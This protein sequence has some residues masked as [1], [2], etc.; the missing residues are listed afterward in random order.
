MRV[1]QEFFE[2]RK[3]DTVMTVKSKGKKS[4]SSLTVIEADTREFSNSKSPKVKIELKK[5]DNYENK[6]EE[7]KK[8]EIKKLF[9]PTKYQEKTP[10]SKSTT[11]KNHFLSE[12]S[13]MDSIQNSPMNKHNFKHFFDKPTSS[14]QGT[15]N[16]ENLQITQ[17]K[18]DKYLDNIFTDFVESDRR[19][20][21]TTIDYVLQLLI[22][23]RDNLNENPNDQSETPHKPIKLKMRY[24]ATGLSRD[25][26]YRKFTTHSSC[27][28]R[29][30]SSVTV[31]DK[32]RTLEIL[33][34]PMIFEGDAYVLVQLKDISNIELVKR[35][36]EVNR[37]RNSSLAHIIHEFRSPLNGALSMLELAK[38]LASPEVR[39]KYL[40]PAY[41]STSALLYLVNDI[42][43]LH[44]MQA[45][46]LRLVFANSRLSEICENAMNMIKFKADQ[47]GIALEI[48]LDDL[49]PK[50][51]YTDP[52]RLQQILVNLL[53]NAVKF[54]ENGK[55]ALQ[56]T[57]L[58]PRKVKLQVS[59]TGIGIESENL[60]KLFKSFGK[61]DLGGKNDLNPQGAGLGLYISNGLAKRLNFTKGEGGLSVTSEV[62]KGTCFSFIVEDIKRGSEN[63]DLIDE[64]ESKKMAKM[65]QGINKTSSG[66]RNKDN[67]IRRLDVER[68]LLTNAS[69][70][71][72][73]FLTLA[74]EK[75]EKMRRCGCSRILIADDDEMNIWALKAQLEIFNI[76]NV[77]VARNGEEAVRKFKEKVSNNMACCQGTYLLILMDCEMPVKNGLV[78]TKEIKKYAKEHSC[79]SPMII[80][81]SG[82]SSADIL[83]KCLDAGMDTSI[84]KPVSLKNLKQILLSVN[85]F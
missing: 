20:V 40:V 46:E 64:V 27:A 75:S 68:D 21:R 72:P 41:T 47:R 51:I 63:V 62:G 16:D 2:I 49:L 44:Q 55:I 5:T 7:I 39:D 69:L 56:A 82:H 14:D 35:L 23:L 85:C 37:Q 15:F 66:V 74:S 10:T 71:S 28:V 6:T 77:D 70:H 43:D 31:D 11:A 81:V 13:A 76:V 3:C 17:D 42:L 26:F 32:V 58:P 22:D 4:V 67:N 38:P 30:E 84:T 45:K 36:K 59:D 57:Y 29:V 18:M 79:P 53:S 50:Y 33:L 73:N 54:T 48:I 8:S 24:S 34:N 12:K 61:I 65:L 52:N 60:Q 19:D 9:T 83:R 1:P 25:H 78:A 80:G